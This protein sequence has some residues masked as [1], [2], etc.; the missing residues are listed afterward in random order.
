MSELEQKTFQKRQI[1][2]KVNILDI[3]NGTNF[4]RVNIIATLVYKSED[5]NYDSA[6]ID[7]GGGRILVR[8]F[9]KSN[10]FSNVDVGDVVLVVGKIRDFN[11]ER[12]II[13]EILKKVEDAGWMNVRKLELRKSSVVI[14]DTTKDK[15]G[16]LIEDIKL[17]NHAE[18]YDLIKKLDEGDGVL[19]DDVI[20]SSKIGDAEE[21]INRLLENGDIFEIKPGKL[22]ILE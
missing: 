15:N 17:D 5:L 14:E 18:V 16:G 19:I 22:K 11:N 9:E 4:S 2:C 6:I 3:L 1:A 8:G 7:D 21:I 20:K 10:I 13:P 12:Y